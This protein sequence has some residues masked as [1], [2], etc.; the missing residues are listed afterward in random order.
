MT[1]KK[2]LQ[3]DLQDVQQSADCYRETDDL[4]ISLKLS[5][6]INIQNVSVHNFDLFTLFK[7]RF[8]VSCT[9]YSEFHQNYLWVA[10][11]QPNLAQI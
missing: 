4:K 3:Q 11:K 10:E 2:D 6:M 7:R 9:V 1:L 5:G 8:L